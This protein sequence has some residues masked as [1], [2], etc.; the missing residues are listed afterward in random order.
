MIKNDFLTDDIDPVYFVKQYN[1][2]LK[3]TGADLDWEKAIIFNSNESRFTVI[4]L[5]NA[6]F[7]PRHLI[8]E[9]EI[10]DFVEHLSKQINLSE[11]TL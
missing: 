4:Y 9:Y 2:F 5:Q 3:A 6:F 10:P 1:R 11:I 8:F 7:Y